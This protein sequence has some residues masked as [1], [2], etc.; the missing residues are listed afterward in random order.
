M[1]TGA[2]FITA[3]TENGWRHVERR[4]GASLRPSWASSPAVIS[5]LCLSNTG[6]K[7]FERNAFATL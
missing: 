5:L 3:A 6:T 1:R 4:Q 2:L 7:R